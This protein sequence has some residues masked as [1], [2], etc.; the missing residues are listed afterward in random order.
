MVTSIKELRALG[1]VREVELPGWSAG[2]RVTFKLGRPSLMLMVRDGRIPNRLL[3]AAQG[4][5]SGTGAGNGESGFSDAVDVMITVVRATMV[6]PTYDEIINAGIELT[7]EQM[8]AIFQYSQNGAKAL[9]RFRNKPAHG[10]ADSDE[11]NAA[12]RAE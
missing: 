9:E 12:P 5:F 1:S 2:E 10:D 7:D 11:R 4:L 3:N 6:E 8:V